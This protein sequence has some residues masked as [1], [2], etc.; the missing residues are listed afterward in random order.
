MRPRIY[1]SC[2]ISKG[3]RTANFAAACQMQKQLMEL[4]CAPLNPALSMM[5]P[6]AWVIDHAAWIECDLPWVQVADAVLRIPGESVGADT[7][8]AYAE[9]LG[10]PIFNSL[11]ELLLWLEIKRA[12]A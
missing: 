12:I 11:S 6:D 1:I 2:A 3:D 4:N 10:I 5:H 7:E 9:E 8:V